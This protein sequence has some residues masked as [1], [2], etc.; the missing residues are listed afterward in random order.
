MLFVFSLLASLRNY[1]FSTTMSSS[2]NFQNKNHSYRN[3]NNSSSAESSYPSFDSSIPQPT[4]AAAQGSYTLNPSTFKICDGKVLLDHHMHLEGYALPIACKWFLYANFPIELRTW[5]KKTNDYVR[6]LNRVAIVKNLDWK[7][8]G[9]FDLIMLSS[10]DIPLRLD[11][12]FAFAGF[13]SILLVHPLEWFC[14]PFWNAK[15]YSAGCCDN[16]WVAPYGEEPSALHT[17]P[18][19]GLEIKFSKLISSY[20]NF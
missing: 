5:P 1:F 2:S 6:W 19:S 18:V 9:I 4:I 16:Y 15:S 8:W 12:L 20:T 14:L 11:L 7:K 3:D 17:T 13:W 10:H